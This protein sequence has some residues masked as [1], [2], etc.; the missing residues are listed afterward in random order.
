MNGALEVGVGTVVNVLHMTCHDMT[1]PARLP[2]PSPPLLSSRLW[3][4]WMDVDVDGGRSCVWRA[5]WDL[6]LDL[7]WHFE[8]F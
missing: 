7:D 3:A 6:D 1:W 2:S 8:G 5:C 4:S